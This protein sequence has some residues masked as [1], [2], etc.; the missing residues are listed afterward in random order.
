[1]RHYNLVKYT[2]VY[3]PWQLINTL[4]ME[5]HVLIFCI[6]V[7]ISETKPLCQKNLA[8]VAL[9]VDDDNRSWNMACRLYLKLVMVSRMLVVLL[10]MTWNAY[11][12]SAIWHHAQQWYAL[13]QLLHVK[14]MSTEQ[15]LAHSEYPYND[16]ALNQVQWPGWAWNNRLQIV[17]VVLCN[18]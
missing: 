6:A 14:L 7:D 5:L 16:L 12:V 17:T 2:A 9:P 3:Y 10:S 1:M 11:T 13:S 15:L 18:T 4:F 8:S